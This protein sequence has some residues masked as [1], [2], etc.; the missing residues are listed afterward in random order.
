MREGWLKGKSHQHESQLV[1]NAQ[2][3]LRWIFGKYTN[4]LEGKTKLSMLW[5]V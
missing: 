1:I 3:G 2:T 4:F 5:L